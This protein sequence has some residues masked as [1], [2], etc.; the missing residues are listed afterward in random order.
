MRYLA[1]IAF[2]VIVVAKNA[3]AAEG[4]FWCEHADECEEDLGTVEVTTTWQSPPP[5]ELSCDDELFSQAIGMC[6]GTIVDTPPEPRPPLSCDGVSC[7]PD[8]SP[9]PSAPPSFS[10]SHPIALA[11]L[12]RAPAMHADA[13]ALMRAQPLADGF[14]RRLD[15]PPRVSA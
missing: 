2:F 4:A 13:L 15:R 12:W 6:E 9:V 5:P 8:D 7:F 3:A 11:A 14:P 10:Y 1:L